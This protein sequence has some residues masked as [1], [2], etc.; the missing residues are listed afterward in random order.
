[1][2][3]ALS[4]ILLVVMLATVFLAGGCG[5][6]ET[7]APTQPS[8]TTAPGK[9]DPPET[10]AEPEETVEITAIWWSN[11]GVVSDEG[12]T[13]VNEALEEITVPLINVKVNLEIWDVGTYVSQAATVVANNEDVDLMI[14]FRRRRP[15]HADDRPENAVA[16][17][18]SARDLCTGNPASDSRRLVVRGIPRR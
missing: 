17:R 5:G 14:T 6:V 2:K 12:M 11:G 4:I 10:T 1:M 18:R 8:S 7:T 13:K 16:P 15:L 3:K 9:T